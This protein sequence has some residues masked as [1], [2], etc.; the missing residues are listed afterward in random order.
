M[1]T[2]E[3][4]DVVLVRFPFTDLSSTKKRPAVVISPTSYASRHGNLIVLGLT[5]Q[6]QD[7]PS[8]LRHWKRAGLLKPT[9]ATHVAGTL[10]FSVVLRRLGKLRPVDYA[11]VQSSLK[12]MIATE[13]LQ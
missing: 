10:H 12:T 11:C 1:T 9:W 4:G 3:P 5:S 6:P 7:D 13:F 2:Y 8:R